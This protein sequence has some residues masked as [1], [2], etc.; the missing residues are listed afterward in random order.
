MA[1]TKW[2]KVSLIISNLNGKEML[3]ECLR[4]LERLIY[5]SYEIIVVDAGSTDGSAEMVSIEFPDVRLLR[6]ERIGIYEAINKGLIAAQGDIIAFNLNNDEIFSEDWLMVLV[7]ELLSSEEKKVVGGVRVVYGSN[8]IVD[9]AGGQ[10]GYTGRDFIRGHGKNIRDIPQSPREVTYLGMAVFQR[11][12]LNKIGLCDEKYYVR[13]GDWDFC[14]KARRAGYKIVSVPSAVSYHR[15]SVTVKPSSA[16]NLYYSKRNHVR[17]FI[18]HYPPMQMLVALLVWVAYMA[19]D[20][21]RLF[22]PTRRI[23]LLT[24]IAHTHVPS[25]KLSELFTALLKSLWWNLENL[26]NHFKARRVIQSIKPS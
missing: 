26:G 8:G 1:R 4:S 25:E 2:P 6:E 14:E 11:G 15:R 21:I 18:K 17:L 9:A 22:P 5:P 16:R 23:L 3:K 19:R 7:N 12:L 20:I 10:V 13:A 24:G